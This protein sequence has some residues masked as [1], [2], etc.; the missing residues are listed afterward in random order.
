MLRKILNVECSFWR[1]EN[2]EGHKCL[3]GFLLCSK[4]VWLLLKMLNARDMTLHLL[5]P[6]YQC[7]NLCH[8]TPS[9]LMRFSVIWLVTLPKPQDVLTGRR[10]NYTVTIRHNSSKIIGCTCQVSKTVLHEMLR[11]VA[12][13]MNSLHKIPKRWLC[14]ED[15]TNKKYM[16]SLWRNQLSPKIIWSYHAYPKQVYSIFYTHLYAAISHLLTIFQKMMGCS[17][18]NRGW[19]RQLSPSLWRMFSNSFRST[20]GLR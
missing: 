2:K 10:N 17:S 3:T 5:T 14:Q 18:T 15:N 6:L 20:R 12:W 11:V 7:M 1:A 8:S 19:V 4:L 16:L 9:L 13:S